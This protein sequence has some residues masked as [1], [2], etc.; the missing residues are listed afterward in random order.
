MEL[1]KSRVYMLYQLK[2]LIDF[3]FAAKS[4]KGLAQPYHV[5]VYEWH[6]QQL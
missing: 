2:Y 3:K 5:Q 1:K 4:C 6:G